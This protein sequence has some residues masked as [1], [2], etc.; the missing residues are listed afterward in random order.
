MLDTKIYYLY[1]LKIV[2]M[3]LVKKISF[4]AFVLLI[5]L[6]LFYPT[7]VES[8]VVNNGRVGDEFYKFPWTGGM[9]SM[10]FGEIDLNLDGIMDLVA[11]DRQ[12]NR[13]IP[14]VNGGA[15][16]VID[17]SYAP[18]FVDYFPQLFDWAI[19]ADYN[20]DGKVDIFTY[21]PGW[22][23]MMVYEN[24]S[25]GNLKFKRVV[26]PY[27]SS[28]YSGGEVNI[29][30]TYADY[31]AIVDLDNDGDLDILTFWGLGSFVEMHKNV[32]MEEY[33][34]PD[35]LVFE[36]TEDC[37][38]H[39]AESDESNELFLDTC[40]P[41]G[42]VNRSRGMIRQERHTGSTFLMIDL[43]NDNDKDLLL[44][45]VDYPGIFAL[46]NGGTP[47]EANII[48]YDT[49]FPQESKLLRLFSM[50]A[51]A[52]IDVNN[53]GVKDLIVSPF[54]PAPAI[55]RNFHS[56][57][58]Y[59]NNGSDSSPVFNFI[60]DAFLQGQT[61]DVGSGSMPVFFD[62]DNDGLKDLFV[63]NYGYYSGSWYDDYFTLHSSYKGTVAY[64]KN[65]G[66]VDE[67]VFKSTDIDF[68]G[69]LKDGETLTGISPTFGDVNGDGKNEMVVGNSDG[70]LI[71]V[72]FSPTVVK[73]PNYFNIDVGDFSTPQ[74]FDLDNDGL[75]DLI[76]GEQNGNLNYYHNDGSAT[77]PDFSFVTDSLGKVN[78]TDYSVSWSGYSIP[79]F[80]RTQQGETVLVVGSEQ[81]KLFYYTNIDGNLS[82]A[83][84]QSDNLADL[85]GLPAFDDDRGMRT[86]ASLADIDD[87]G[88]P[89]LVAG[90]FCGGLE[91][92]GGNPEVALSVN[93]VQSRSNRLTVSPNPASKYVQI[94]LP[95]RLSQCKLVFYNISGKQVLTHTFKTYGKTKIELNVGGLSSGFYTVALLTN[96]GKFVGK[97]IISR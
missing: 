15:A 70:T 77:N 62:W 49:L 89:E 57:W 38:G 67:P 83:F 66:T 25:T 4:S 9:N 36:K 93:A 11:F 86:A 26:Y 39:F 22:A 92:F 19:F 3:V 34:I 24:I 96:N 74:L 5:L 87:D 56:V 82:G 40:V 61:I 58:L 10:Q 41:T 42:F 12:G 97:L 8:Q 46:T 79:W 84:T 60:T 69:F 53:D 76:I 20:N 78:V 95:E 17:Y 13:I 31:P 64:F 48:S 80:Y 85:I 65:I 14:F 16:N 30:V 43:D 45:D 75:L 2:I 18:Q 37:W 29:F 94:T 6:L 71:F 35:S 88:V 23:G 27:L 55:S 68:G 32:S 33:G 47:E 51:A 59:I 63:G 21:S 91:Y 73:T 90:N 50:P 81:G 72:Q 44:G 52:Y 54:D 1:N 28:L 7:M